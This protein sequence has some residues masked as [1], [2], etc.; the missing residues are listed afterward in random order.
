MSTF[1][2]AAIQMRSGIDV[3]RNVEALE[4][5]V[6]DAAAQGAHYIQTPEM[7]GA[8]MRDRP[9]L[10]QACAMK[11]TTW[12]SGRLAH[13]RPGMA[14][15]CISVRRQSM[16]APARSPIA[17]GFLRHRAKRLPLM[18][19]FICSMSISTMAKAG[20]DRR[21]VSPAGKPSSR[22]CLSPKWAWRSATISVSRSFSGTG[23]GW[24]KCH[25]R[26]CCFHAPDW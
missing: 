23:A 1:R 13:W 16:Q 7:T 6:A 24:R 17:A 21:P 19:R 26:P 4:K 12:S 2:A 20:A 3:V 22:N 10:L 9:A 14:S 8:L 11:R 15:S 5:L 18:T 25:H